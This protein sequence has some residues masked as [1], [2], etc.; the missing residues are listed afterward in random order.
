MRP[1]SGQIVSM[2]VTSVQR[3]GAKKG[4]LPS[5]DLVPLTKQMVEEKIMI[6]TR[7]P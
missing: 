3:D 6:F 5:E 7:Q 4:Q 1:K 2:V